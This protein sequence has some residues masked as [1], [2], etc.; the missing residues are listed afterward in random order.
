LIAGALKWS[1][2]KKSEMKIAGLLHDIGKI[3][4]PARLLNKAEKL[5]D[6]EFDIIKT[7]A[8]TSYQILKSVDEYVTIAGFVLHHH[9][10]WD[11]TGYPAGLKGEEIPIQ[12]RIIAVADAFEAMT[13]KRPYQKTRTVEEAKKELLRCSGTQ[14]DPAVVKVFLESVLN[15]PPA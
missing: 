12:S 13:A 3:I 10:H 8:E 14:F 1:A 15:E 6:E 4:L 9:E 2:D 7:H 11:G 5:T